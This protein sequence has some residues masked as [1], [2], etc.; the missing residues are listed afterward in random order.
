M[1][2]AAAPVSTATV[3]LGLAQ[4]RLLTGCA[5][6]A[7]LM[8]I[9]DSTIS[10]T[11]LP[12]MQGSLSATMDQITWVLSSYIIVSAIMTA[13]VGWLANRFG[14]KNLF[15]YSM[16]GFTATS[17]LCGMAQTL[18]QM[19]AFRILQGTFGAA[20]AP[21]AQA[22]M[23]D[24]YP[25]E[26]RAQAM[27]IFGLG[28]M[29]GPIMGPTLGGYL[30][31]WF[32]WRWVFYVNVPF[33]ILATFGLIFF[34][35]S[36]AARPEM[37][38]D[39]VGFGVLALAIGSFQLMLDRGQGEDWFTSGEIIACAV[40]AGLGFYLF[41]VHM[42]TA[43]RPLIPRGV[44]KDRNYVASMAMMFCTGCILMASSALLAPFLQKLSGYPPSEAGMMLAPRGAGTMVAMV[45]ASRLGGRYVDQRKLMAFGLLGLGLTL[46]S[47]TTWT[48]DMPSSLITTTLVIQGFC[49][50]FIFNPM[51]VV[52]F[53]TLPP[54]FRADAAALQNL[55]R[56]TGAAIGIAVTSFML[57]RNTQTAHADLAA[58]ITPFPRFTIGSEAAHRLLDPATTKGAGLLD[59]II[60]REATI[61]AFANDYQMLSFM[62][63]PPLLLLFL[64]R[65]PPRVAPAMAAKPAAPATSPAPT[66][67]ATPAA[68]PGRAVS[69]AE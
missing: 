57:A 61:V 41:M 48:P 37:K 50:G 35:P 66:P 20:L 18:E 53:A 11:A 51:T 14:R 9:L 13:P 55:S 7:V 49:M 21:L 36:A 32:H 3:P 69:A 33:G 40:L 26:Q 54:Q 59:S 25:F 5:M 8:Q 39:F 4:R 65:R 44:F 31:D 16:I 42:F 58:N 27:A 10:I 47:M 63:I 68:A 64:M 29:V 23:L 45:I 67:A 2:G 60:T 19:V 43:E 24:I 52:A 12:Y 38:F 34:M 30:T 62:V 56:N 22:T 6:T 28:I 15:I 46:H 1:S 17:V